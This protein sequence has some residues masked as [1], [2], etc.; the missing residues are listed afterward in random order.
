MSADPEF[1]Q[2]L[3]MGSLSAA[4]ANPALKEFYERLLSNGKHKNLAH[5]AV[6]RKLLLQIRSIMHTGIP[7]NPNHKP[8]RD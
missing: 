6:A 2:L 3:Y 7:F 8:K 4:R 5:T 1:R